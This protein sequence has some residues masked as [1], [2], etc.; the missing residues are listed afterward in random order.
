MIVIYEYKIKNG[1]NINNFTLFS[2]NNSRLDNVLLIK[3][4]ANKEKN[5]LTIMDSIEILKVDIP[6]YHISNIRIN[7]KNINSTKIYFFEAS[8]S[9]HIKKVTE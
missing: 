5:I 8:T 6:K 4:M 7:I 9:A 1:I 2:E 3:K